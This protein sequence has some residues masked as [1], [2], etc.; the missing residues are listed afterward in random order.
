MGINTANN[1]RTHITSYKKGTAS[2]SNCSIA[3]KRPAYLDNKC[4]VVSKIKQ[5]IG[6]TELQEYVNQRAGRNIKFLHEPVNLAKEYS[7][8]RT[9]A[10]E[11]SDN[12]YELLSKPEFWD[13]NIQLKDFEG[14]RWWRNKASN[15]S[16]NE[17][18]NSM[19]QQWIPA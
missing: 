17:R 11:L 6:L 3:S 7:R 1:K 13:T 4:I 16:Q 9:L 12:D 15:L 10:I 5:D 2:I 18:Q 19:R 8:W 14:R